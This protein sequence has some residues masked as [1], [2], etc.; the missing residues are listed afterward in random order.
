MKKFNNIGNIYMDEWDLSMKRQ[1]GYP[2]NVGYDYSDVFKYLKYNLNNVGDPF[3]GTNYNL[4]TMDTEK[5]VLQFFSNLWNVQKEHWGYITFSGTEGNM[6]GLLIGRERFPNGVLYTSDQSHYSIFKIVKLFKMDV[7]KI[8]TTLNG[9]MNYTE[10]EKIIDKTRPAIINANIG[11][12][13]KGAVD[14]V[15]KI[16]E[17]LKKSKIEYHLHADGALMG[18]VLPFLYN[19]LS[20]SR[21]IN[22]ISISG[23]K[24]LGV[25]FPCG[26]F[27]VEKKFKEY[28]VQ[29]VEYISSLDATIMGSR[30]GHAP[31]FIYD[32]INKK[33]IGGFRED[34]YQC[35]YIAQWFTNLMKSKGIN[36]WINHHSIT[37]IF[38]RPSDELIKKW[39]IATENEISHV[40]VM[41]HVTKK[42]LHEF[43]DEYIIDINKINKQIF[44]TYAIEDKSNNIDELNENEEVDNESLLD[45]DENNLPVYDLL[46]KKLFSTVM[47]TSGISCFIFLGLK[48][49]KK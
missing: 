43:F 24:F 20:F 42:L 7:V 35:L 29:K 47:L 3:A 15:D 28:I 38:P 45:N 31:L 25:P 6:E 14:D 23:H 12:T 9:E 13:M 44:N 30:N 36:A 49:I 18:F 8:P 22:S 34:I 17:I 48:L 37:V 32:C 40:I 33:G 4:N 26:I 46:Y 1:I 5:E 39:A 10:F 11:T 16:V 27:M 21:Y 41:P 2:V 19:D